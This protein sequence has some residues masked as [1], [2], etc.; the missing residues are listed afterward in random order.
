MVNVSFVKRPPSVYML[1]VRVD[2][3]TQQQ[4][5]DRIE[6]LIERYRASQGQTSCQQLITV[7]PEFVMAAQRDPV[8]RQ[9]INETA[10]VMPDGIG[11]VWAACYL[12]KPTPERVTGVDTLIELAR[13]A[14]IK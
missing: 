6:L 4:V 11:V 10:V 12:G 7:N 9:C 1:G 8:F 5:L 14:A 13:R 3:V 2:R